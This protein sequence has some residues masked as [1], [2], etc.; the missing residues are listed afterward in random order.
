MQ[1]PLSQKVY[2]LSQKILQPPSTPVDIGF[3]VAF[4][5]LEPSDGI[6]RQT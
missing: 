1:T 6:V 3:W 2:P 5:T 4:A